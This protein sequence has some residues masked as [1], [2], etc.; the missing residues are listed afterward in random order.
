VEHEIR[1]GRKSDR[2]ELTV[3][4]EVSGLGPDGQAFVEKTVTLN[5]G[6]HGALLRLTQKLFPEQEVTLSK[7][8]SEPLEATVVGMTEG[9]EDRF[10][11]G[12]MFKDATRNFWGIEF[13]ELSE[14]DKAAARVLL[15]CRVCGKRELTY[16]NEVEMLVFHANRMITRPCGQCAAST[17]WVRAE[18]DAWEGPRPELVA[19]KEIDGRSIKR[20]HTRLKLRMEVCVRTLEYGDDVA[21]L[22]DI[23]R[24]GFGFR[25]RKRYVKNQRVEAATNYRP[26]GPNI[27]VPA[28]ITS[29]GKPD[30]DEFARYGVAYLSEEDAARKKQSPAI[31]S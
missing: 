7:P 24:G 21:R 3:P 16:L 17:A 27:F 22:D 31:D 28:R 20:Q 2:I 1:S 12:L 11:Y 19:A 4:V 26:G 29:A 5:V 30:S 8:G 10:T 15:E 23:S 9:G 18:H 14:A 25:S 6:R 13:P